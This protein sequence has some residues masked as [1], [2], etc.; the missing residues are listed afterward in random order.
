MEFSQVVPIITLYGLAIYRFMPSVNRI[1]TSR[2]A[3]KYNLRALEVV[4]A[5]LG[6]KTAQEMAAIPRRAPGRAIRFAST[7][8]LRGVSFQYT[9]DRA[10]KTVDGLTL[11]IRKGQT[12]GLVGVSG[13]GKTTVVDIL[14]GLLFP[15]AGSVEV[16]GRPLT[17]DDIAAWHG[18]IGSIPQ[19]IFLYDDTLLR[20][21]A[22]GVEDPLIDRQ[23]VMRVIRA[24][25][26]EELVKT[27]P[28]GLDTVVGDRGIR[29]SG[30]QRQRVGI[31]RALY[32][33]PQILV[34][35]EATSSLDAVTE[36][37]I[38]RAIECLGGQ[39]TIV[40]IAHRLTTVMKCD[41]VHLVDKGRII[42]SGS[43]EELLERSAAFQKLVLA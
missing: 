19:D 38:G 7:V 37:E 22:F 17:R 16:D 31:A 2:L 13:S 30:G 39:K 8:S 21:V 41:T 15:D 10:E 1:I 12:I 4:A 24:A 6:G 27:L 3:I 25:Q 34:F 5:A 23:A 9:R 11:D 35:D 43:Y 18:L 42:A 33:D 29:L 40:I 20:N 28:A 32:R 14:L 26:L 36:R